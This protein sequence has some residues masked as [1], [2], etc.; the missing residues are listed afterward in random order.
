[1]VAGGLVK[2]AGFEGA[3]TREVFEELDHLRLPGRGGG[4]QGRRGVVEAR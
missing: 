3:R 1:M 4:G 2:A